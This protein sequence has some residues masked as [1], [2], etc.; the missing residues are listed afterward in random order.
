M[1]FL[2]KECT[3]FIATGLF[4]HEGCNLGLL[5]SASR[6]FVF[7]MQE[8]KSNTSAYTGL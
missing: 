2:N 6:S 4:Q 1:N 5:V 3:K 8:F 7:F